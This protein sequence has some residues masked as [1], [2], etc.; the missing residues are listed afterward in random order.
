MDRAPLDGFLPTSFWYPG[1]A[2]VDTYRVT[3][4][5]AAPPGTYTFYTGFY[6]PETVTRLPAVQ[7]DQTLGDAYLIGRITVE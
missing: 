6:D 3:L 1:Q 7:G 4:P 5:P 2:I